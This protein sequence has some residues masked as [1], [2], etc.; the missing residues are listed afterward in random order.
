MGVL[1]VVRLIGIRHG[2]DNCKAFDY[3]RDVASVIYEDRLGAFVEDV[4]ALRDD[5]IE[6]LNDAD[7][8]RGSFYEKAC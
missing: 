3:L 1:P 2:E 4:W 8:L 5:Y 7:P 6:V